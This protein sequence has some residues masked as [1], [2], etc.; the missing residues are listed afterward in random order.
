MGNQLIYGKTSGGLETPVQVDAAGGL[1]IG[2]I[3]AGEPHIGEVGG[4]LL[5]TST[6]F[7][8]PADTT[9]YSI[10]DVVSN[11][12]GTTTPIALANAVRVNGGTGYVVRASI[13][14]DKKSIVPQF[15]VHLYNANDATLSADNA[16]WQDK[17]A[18]AG[19]R[20]G[21]FDLPAMNTGAD[22]TNSDMSRTQDSTLRHAIKAAANTTTIYAVLETL[23][24]FTPASG[25]KFT[26]TLYIDAN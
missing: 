25:Q 13:T 19:K 3:T 23:T 12:T 5:R 1:Q 11:N 24:A 21:Y 7:T 14:T 6:E 9:G 17:Y 18:D 16:N 4:N 20:L 8:R 15:R 22:T 10:N 2:G 26:L